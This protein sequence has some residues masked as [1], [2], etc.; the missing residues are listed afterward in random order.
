[1]IDEYRVN[2]EKIEKAYLSFIH[3]RLPET[4]QIALDE[5]NTPSSC[6]YEAEINV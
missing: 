1:V 6:L 5:L 4:F 2:N 3:P